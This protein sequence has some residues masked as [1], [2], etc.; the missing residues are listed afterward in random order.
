MV[1]SYILLGIKIFYLCLLAQVSDSTNNN[2][3]NDNKNNKNSN[4]N[5]KNGDN[6]NN[7]NNRR[8]G[9]TY[10]SVKVAE[11]MAGY[12][13]AN[14]ASFLIALGDNFYNNGVSSTSDSLWTTYYTN[15]YNYDSLQIPWYVIFGN[16]DYGTKNGAG[17][18]QAQIDYNTVNSKW[19][20]GYCYKESFT[21]PDS[22]ATMDIVFIDTTLIGNFCLS[23][24]LNSP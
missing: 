18:L 22:S 4:N 10:W 17:S 23:S 16:H 15:I 13:E 14:P 24:H 2:N 9:G 5:N 12:A 11:A 21:I 3:K 6:N 8:L 7:K 1:S 19:T 20:A